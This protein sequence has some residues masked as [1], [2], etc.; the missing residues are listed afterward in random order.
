MLAFAPSGIEGH[1]GRTPRSQDAAR[2]AEKLWASCHLTL[3]SLETFPHLKKPRS[4]ET[5]LLRPSVAPQMIVLLNHDLELRSSSFLLCKR[6][7]AERTFGKAQASLAFHSLNHDLGLCPS[8]F[9]FGKAQASLA[10]HSLNHDLLAVHDEHA[11]RGLHHAATLQVVYWCGS[12]FFT[13]HS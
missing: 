6:P 12:K 4:A 11:L 7:S 13:L 2:P 1:V 10:F 3:A 9:T 5:F 8:S